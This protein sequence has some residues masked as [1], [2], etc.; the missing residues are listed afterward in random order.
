MK[1]AKI[2]IVDDLYANRLALSTI[3]EDL[4]VD[5]FEADSGPVALSYL[6]EVEFAL[7]LLDVQMPGMDGFETAALIRGSKQTQSTPIIFITANNSLNSQLMRAYDLGAVDFLFKPLQSEVLLAKI[8]VFLDLYRQRQLVEETNHQLAAANR[9]KDEFLSI[10]SHELRTPLNGVIGMSQLLDFTQLDETQKAYNEVIKSSGESLLALINDMLEMQRF[11]QNRSDID[12]RVFNIWRMLE[13]PLQGVSRQAAQKGLELVVRIDPEVPG[14]IKGDPEALWKI[15][16]ILIDNG[17]KFTDAGEIRFNVNLVDHPDPK[18]S[19]WLRFEIEDTGIGVAPNKQQEVFELFT[20]GDSSSTRKFGGTGLGLAMVKN[21]VQ[22]L[23]GRLGI[24][25]SCEHGACFWFE[26]PFGRAEDLKPNDH[27]TA[28]HQIE[29]GKRR[30]LLLEENHTRASWITKL[31]LNLGLS[32]ERVRTEDEGIGV[33]QKGA[34][35][36]NPVFM[37]LANCDHRGDRQVHL[38]TSLE[39]MPMCRPHLVVLHRTYQH[40]EEARSQKSGVFAQLLI[41]LQQKALTL[42]LINS[43]QSGSVPAGETELSV[44]KS[45]VDSPKLLYVEDN[46]FNR[47][48]M[49]MLIDSIGIHIETVENGAEAVKLLSKQNFNLV[50]MDCKMPVMDGYEATRQI[51][52]FKNTATEANVPI[53]A[54]TATVLEGEKERCFEAGMN[55]FLTKPIDSELLFDTV[56]DCLNE[57][58]RLPPNVHN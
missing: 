54:V 39:S 41:P 14:S 19:L 47:L 9:S 26:L 22:L 36:G 50:L 5:I 34:E 33:C 23:S 46:Y 15:L 42:C 29:F 45:L 8:N 35:Q 56:T 13:H 28:E 2:L 27:W 17:I 55:A 43:M 18:D 37:F 57:Q 11:S 52:S 6:L 1:K 24:E 4:E 51:R 25:K 10:I 12:V 58:L 32:L 38:S 21:L 7:V 3:L 31:F 48:T 49:K 40:K 44:G 30:F 20:Q 53:I 16:Q